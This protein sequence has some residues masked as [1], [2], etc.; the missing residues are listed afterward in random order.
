MFCGV[1]LELIRL[2][3]VKRLDM[4]LLAQKSQVLSIVE[5]CYLFKSR[6]SRLVEIHGIFQTISDDQLL[7][8]R[9]APWLHR[10]GASK[11]MVFDMWV[12]VKRYAVPFWLFQTIFFRLFSNDVLLF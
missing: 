5:E 12:V 4:F 1:T 10:M 6:R 11:M 7:R 3:H 8:E 9:Q 2:C